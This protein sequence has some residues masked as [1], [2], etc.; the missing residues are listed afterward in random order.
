[1]NSYIA[2]MRGSWS[3]QRAVTTAGAA[4]NLGMV[5]GPL[6]GG[7][8]GEQIGL[9]MVFRISAVIFLLSTLIIF[10]ARRPAALEH[11]ELPG[12]RRNLVVNP[13]FLGLLA[14]IFFTIFALFLPQPLTS[15]Y[16]KEQQAFS[17]QDVGMLGTV[18]SFGNV[19][20]LLALGRLSA[21]V[22][23]LVGQAMVGLFALLL[24]Q[25]TH[26]LLFFTG[27]FFVGGYRL[28]RSMTLAYT[29]STVRSSE[30]GLAFGLVETV[31]AF[32]V[33]LA[34]LAAGFLYQRSP[35]SI[36]IVSLAAIL[37]MLSINILRQQIRRPPA[38]ILL[39]PDEA[40]QTHP[41]QA[42]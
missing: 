15:I 8:I 13:R 27:Y 19:V 9:R 30:I 6:L 7:W 25:G 14:M 29:R 34:P 35:Q 11:V 17:V 41:T 26:P 42:D 18:G 38:D 10:L 3:V 33:I 37:G 39:P 23:M 40:V 1:M 2:S 36:Y 32:S 20:I 5:A 28:F 24:W 12:P 4:F 21:P 22:G 31:S 16:L